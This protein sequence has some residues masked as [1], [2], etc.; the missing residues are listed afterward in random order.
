MSSL[1]LPDVGPIDGAPRWPLIAKELREIVAGRALWVMV[2]LVCPLIGYS[3]DQAIALYAEASAAVVQSPVMATSLTPLD[4]VLVPTF[5][6]FYVAVTLLFPFVAIRALGQEKETGA[7][8]LLLQLP[9]GLPTLIIAKLTAVLAAFLL[10]ALP[11]ISAIVV[12][13]L[14]GGHVHPPE[15]LNLLLGHALYGLLVGAIALFC[16]AICDSAAT[17]AIVALAFTIGSWVLDFTAAGQPGL[18]GSLARLSL[19]QS[20]RPFEQG[21]LSPGLVAGIL[22]AVGGFAALAGIWLP[23]GRSLK[24]KAAGSAG[25]VLTSALAFGLASQINLSIDVTEDRRNSFSPADQRALSALPLRLSITVHLA[26]EDP[27]YLDLQRNVLAKL[28]R[29]LP[30]VTIGLA[31]GS[32]G[33]AASERAESYGEIELAYGG[34]AASSR[35]T[36]PRELLPLIY[37]LAA[38]APPAPA[39]GADYPGYPLVANGAAARAW[40]FGA[41]PFVIVVGWWRSRR[42]PSL[43]RSP[44]NQEDICHE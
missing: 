41:L 35:S 42:P 20:L 6:A 22:V 34:R 13:L 8:R 1:R 7:L 23:P 17:A 44:S 32:R 29:T 33:F 27:R 37:G 21:L 25:C 31:T 43:S 26:P 12:W 19:T 10:V 38:T 18:A 24:A 15:T 3:L 40:F 11:A 36:S 4:G 30:D 28:E 39:D 5:G 14:L 9:F 2:L 16:A